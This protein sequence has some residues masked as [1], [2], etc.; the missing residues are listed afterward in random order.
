MSWLCAYLPAAPGYS[1]TGNPTF[2]DGFV[3][4]AWSRV[5]AGHVP[6]PAGATFDHELEAGDFCF[7][8]TECITEVCVNNRCSDVCGRAGACPQ[9]Q[10][11]TLFARNVLPGDS[12][13]TELLMPVCVT[14]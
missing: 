3:G 9:G 14:P 13:S 8:D 4:Q 1:Q 5:C 12:S 11:C 2:S 6:A 10:V 7:D